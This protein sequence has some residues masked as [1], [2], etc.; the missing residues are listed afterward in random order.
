MLTSVPGSTFLGIPEQP[1]FRVETLPLQDK[2]GVG[3]TEMAVAAA[4]TAKDPSRSRNLRGTER[5]DP[6][7]QH[8]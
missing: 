1:H 8:R 7:Q 5:T 6:T 3:R 4:L 2:A